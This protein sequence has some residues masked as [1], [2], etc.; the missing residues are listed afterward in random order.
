MFDN[1]GRT[2]DE[3]AVTRSLLAFGAVAGVVG[4]IWVTVLCY[5]LIRVTEQVT[6][7][8]IIDEDLVELQLDDE[9]ELEAPPPPP[10][11]PPP[12]A[13]AEPEEEEEPDDEPEEEPDEMVEEVEELKEKIED[14]Q[15]TTERKGGVEG[16]VE[17]GEE[18][19]VVGGVLG[20]VKGGEIGGQLGG[21]VRAVHHSEVRTKSRVMP[22]YPEAARSMNLGNVNCRVRIF[23]DE[24][25]S[26]YDVQ[27]EACPKVF[28]AATSEAIYKWRWYPARDDDRNKVKAQFLLNIAY[29]LK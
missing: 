21:G 12:P 29:K 2:N 13:A 3:E 24:S 15:V 19:G 1:V 26:P 9:L 28:H 22:L 10:P 27:F 25:G 17:G 11:P 7:M 18:G 8:D 5:G 4:F 20:G 6:G 16:G 14:K 23:I